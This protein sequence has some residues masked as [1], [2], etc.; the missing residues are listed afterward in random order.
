MNAVLI[1]ALAIEFFTYR[2]DGLLGRVS[3]TAAPRL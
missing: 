3:T 2:V 1:E